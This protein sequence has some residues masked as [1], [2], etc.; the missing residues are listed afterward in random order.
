MYF[1][2]KL[3]QTYGQLQQQEE[4]V[5]SID[6]KPLSLQIYE[7]EIEKAEKHRNRGR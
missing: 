3:D 5:A 7:K 6:N 1:H 4:K 2:Q